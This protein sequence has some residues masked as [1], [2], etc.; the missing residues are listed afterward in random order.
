M[1]PT[2]FVTMEGATLEQ[3]V[4]CQ[5]AIE[6]LFDAGFF[7]ITAGSF[8]THFDSR[9]KIKAWD[10]LIKRQAEA[11]VDYKIDNIRNSVKVI[12]E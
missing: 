2:I 5:R 6:Q 8:N 9:G 11:D 4:R 3:A 7:N 10:V 12:V 1:N